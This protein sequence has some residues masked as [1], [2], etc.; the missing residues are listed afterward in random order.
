MG[1]PLIPEMRA[2]RNAFAEAV[3]RGEAGHKKN[4]TPARR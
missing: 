4:P 1:L 3:A 2:V